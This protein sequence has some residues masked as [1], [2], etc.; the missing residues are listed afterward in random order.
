MDEFADRSQT[1]SPLKEAVMKL[2][3]SLGAASSRA[4]ELLVLAIAVFASCSIAS[5][6]I[7]VPAGL[8]PGSQYR[9]AFVT[10]DGYPATSANIATYNN[11]V[12]AE[13]NPV[14]AL[15]ALGTT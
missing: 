7:V 15:A 8:A 9:L 4:L 10:A 3:N 5:P 6:I 1:G 2:I 11:E 14:A 13:A 12:N